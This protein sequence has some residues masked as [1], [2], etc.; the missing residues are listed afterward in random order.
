MML[1]LFLMSHVPYPGMEKK[2]G[3]RDE[4]DDCRGC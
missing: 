4:K 2:T 1:E 3:D